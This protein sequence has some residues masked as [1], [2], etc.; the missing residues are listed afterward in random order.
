MTQ[1]PHPRRYSARGP[2]RARRARPAEGVLVLGVVVIIIVTTLDWKSLAISNAEL[3]TMIVVAS[4]VFVAGALFPSGL[5]FYLWH[6]FANAFAE[7]E[8]H[9]VQ[10][11]R[12]VDGDT[13]DDA[14]SGIRYRFANIDAPETGERARCERERAR[15][16]G[17]AAFV[18]RALRRATSVS[19]RRT[20]RTDVFGRRVAFV[21]VDGQDLG[22][23]L[24]RAGFARPWRGRRRKWCGPDGGLAQIAEAGGFPHACRAC[25]ANQP[26]APAR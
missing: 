3:T 7:R 22:E 20:F 6:G 21:L 16:E 18:E 11:P 26:V 19:V 14:A 9:R 5:A 2:K 13:I 12:T 10:M 8:P 17:A 4:I 1:L 15:G 24:V 23:M 25:G